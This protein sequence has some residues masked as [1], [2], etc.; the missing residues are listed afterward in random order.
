MADRSGYKLCTDCSFNLYMLISWSDQSGDSQWGWVQ[1]K[2]SYHQ[3]TSF[4]LQAI[5]GSNLATEIAPVF[6]NGWLACRTILHEAIMITNGDNKDDLNIMYGDILMK[7]FPCAPATEGPIYFP[8]W[9]L[10]PSSPDWGT[11]IG[12][13]DWDWSG[14]WPGHL[15]YWVRCTTLIKHVQRPVFPLLHHPLPPILS[16]WRYIRLTHWHQELQMVA[17]WIW[18]EG[19]A[20]CNLSTVSCPSMT[21]E[22][23]TLR[24]EVC[25]MAS[26]ART[27]VV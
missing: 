16:T 1:S 24:N 4:N 23:R 9:R 21:P 2:L 8:T 7:F 15:L 26:T 19:K 6:E 20:L 27:E 11:E 5:V 14:K 18:F 12:F 17:S 3:C 13:T 22:E 25:R 10:E